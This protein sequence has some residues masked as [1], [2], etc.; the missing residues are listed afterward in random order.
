VA[1]TCDWAYR[2]LIG[3]GSSAGGGA[4]ERRLGHRGSKSREGGGGA[5]TCVSVGTKWGPTEVL[6]GVRR[7]RSER[8][9]ELMGGGGNSS[10]V[11]RLARARMSVSAFYKRR[12]EQGT[13]GFT[14]KEKKGRKGGPIV[15]ALARVTGG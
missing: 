11:E 4:G 1:Q 8:R 2:E 14:S 9:R 7:R 13:R 3:G 6:R 15:A 10:V 5:W 12:V